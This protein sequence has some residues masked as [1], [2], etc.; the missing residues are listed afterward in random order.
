MPLESGNKPVLELTLLESVSVGCV[1]NYYV[2]DEK[3]NWEENDYPHHH[4]YMH[5]RRLGCAL[6]RQDIPEIHFYNGIPISSWADA[7]AKRVSDEWHGKGEFPESTAILRD[8]FL[9]LLVANPSECRELIGTG[10]IEA[11]YFDEEE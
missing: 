8:V 9:R 5:L 6:A 7:I 4:T 3:R 1:V 11:T 10:V 2:Q